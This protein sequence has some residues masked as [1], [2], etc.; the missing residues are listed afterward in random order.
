MNEMSLENEPSWFAEQFELVTVRA[1]GITS[2]DMVSPG[3]ELAE[4][5]V[6]T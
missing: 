4:P 6:V 5:I 3:P 2:S 1:F